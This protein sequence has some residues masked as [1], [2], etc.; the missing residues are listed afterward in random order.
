MR[1][2]WTPWE[3]LL[4]PNY[5]NLNEAGEWS[6]LLTLSS[7]ER[8]HSNV[9][10]G[11]QAQPVGT[12]EQK[13]FLEKGWV[14][15]NCRENNFSP[16]HSWIWKRTPV[17]DVAHTY[18]VVSSLKWFFKKKKEARNLLIKTVMWV[19]KSATQKALRCQVTTGPWLSPLWKV[20]YAVSACIVPPWDLH[21][22]QCRIQ[23]KKD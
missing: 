17:H 21:L 18:M 6:L 13:H 4:S 11:R 23:M 12:R 20:H 1:E 2:I 5:F 7:L 16:Q 14:T 19:A 10:G 3:A 22:V 8:L 9:G 15:M